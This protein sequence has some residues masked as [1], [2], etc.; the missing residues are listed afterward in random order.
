MRMCADTTLTIDPDFHAPVFLPGKI[1]LLRPGPFKGI[2]AINTSTLSNGLHKLHFRADVY[3][4]RGWYE[5][6][7][8]PT[9]WTRVFPKGS[10]PGVTISGVFLMPFIV[11]N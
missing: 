7:R 1:Q 8:S 5:S 11:A 6:S 10:F 3:V 9:N 2:V 4:K